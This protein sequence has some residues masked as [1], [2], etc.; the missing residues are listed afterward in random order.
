MKINPRELDIILAHGPELTAGGLDYY[1][2]G[3][4]AAGLPNSRILA[5]APMLDAPELE[6]RLKAF[7]HQGAKNPI[8][9]AALDPQH[10]AR[11]I[12]RVLL[13]E[14]ALNPELLTV[15]DLQEAMGYPDPR[16]CS[17]KAH[18][19]IRLAASMVTR[20]QPI[21][22]QELKVS[23]QV[24]VWGDSYA[25]LKAAADLAHLGYQ[26]F[27][28]IP[29]A[30]PGPVIPCGKSTQVPTQ[31]LENLG[32][33]VQSLAAVHLIPGAEIVEVQGSAGDFLVKLRTPQGLRQEKVGALILAPE[34]LLAAIPQFGETIS[35]PRVLHHTRLEVLLASPGEAEKLLDPSADRLR[36]ALVGGDSNPLALRR[37]LGSVSHLLAWDNCQVFL[38]IRD[39]KVGAPDM[40]AILEEAQGAGLIVFK[41]PQLPAL[42]LDGE[43][44]RLTFYDPVMHQEETIP[45][46]LVIL[47]EAQQPAPGNASLAEILRLFPGPAGFLQADNVRN[48]PVIT[49]RRG[50]YVAGPGR[51]AVDLDQAFF[52]A[53]AA[54]SEVHQLLGAGLA[55]AP[56]GRAVIDR[57]RCVLCLTCHRL[58]PHGAVTWDNRAII[59]ELACQGC[60]VC[61]SQCPNEAIQI[62]NFSDDQVIAAMNTLD[63]RLTPKIVAFMCKNSAWEAYHAAL[64]MDQAV[65]PLGFT[66]LRMPCAGKIDIDYLIRA[67]TMGADGVLVL[68]CHPD[69]C[70][71]QQGNEHALWRVERA[72]AML[73]ETG[74]DPRRLVFQTL[75]A[76]S[77][78]GFLTAVDQLIMNLETLK[79]A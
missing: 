7:L 79:A 43:L 74:V 41:L 46:D 32:R 72:R 22:S 75:A 23:P 47:D 64:K 42:S 65:L 69:N 37:A 9:L 21:T 34:M 61:A 48:L 3:L 53:D 6:A 40:E 5:L 24:L 16:A 78:R 54:V 71:S 35:H 30:L 70:K 44:P 51:G 50:I 67:F 20:A 15:L 27:H 28:A 10:R 14:F 4:W 31:D 56:K 17:L 12:I 11:T 8:L 63:P 18:N 1:K 59:N 77:P 57:G 2:L 29:E 66:P 39:A 25:A 76:N 52:E 49:N 60:G 13:D 73:A 62:H 58:C 26:V 38:F 55:Q 36:V 45:C 33:E 68:A 19:L